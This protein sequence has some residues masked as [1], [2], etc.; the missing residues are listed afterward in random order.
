MMPTKDEQRIVE[1]EQEITKLRSQLTTDEL[2]QIL[3]RKGLIEILKPWAREV[4]YQLA[5]PDRRKALI[6]RALSL[7]FVD[8]DHFKNVND[9]YG[10]QAGDLAL[11]TIA[12]ILREN[13]REIDIVGRYGG[14]EMVIGLIGANLQDARKIAEHLRVK[15]ADTP[16]K[17]RDQIIII[18]ASFGVAALAAD[19]NLDDLIRNADEAL[20][21]AKNSGR[22]KVVTA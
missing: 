20:Y 17:F 19:L 12:K 21:R 9:T 5:N 1:L 18:T 7:V 15:I 10:H 2:T 16:V 13:V 22:N 6:V 8:V 14:E 3:N 4:A 11:K